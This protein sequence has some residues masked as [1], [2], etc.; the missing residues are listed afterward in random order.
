MKRKILISSIISLL[1][2]FIFIQNVY[3][4]QIFVKTQTGKTITLE[5]ESSYTIDELKAKIQE[6][7]SIDPK[8]QILIWAGKQLQDGRTLA[9][10]NIK[11]ES[12]INL[13]V[14]EE[15]P[16]GTSNSEVTGN[17][18][19]WLK[20]ESNG[21]SFWFGIDNSNGV[22][23]EQSQFW[24]RIISKDNDNAEWLNYY[25]NIDKE[26]KNDNLLMF[27]IGVTN[28]NG[29]EY[30]MLNEQVKVY[31]Q[32]PD[33][34][35]TDIKGICI[36]EAIDENIYSEI[37]ELDYPDGKTNFAALTLNHFSPY[38]IYEQ[39]YK[40]V[41]DANGGVFKD[42]K[43]TLTIEE[44]QIGDEENLEKPTKDGYKFL[45]Y[46]TEK[47][48]GTSLE[49]YIAEAGIDND[50]TF[51]AQWEELIIEDIENDNIGN[52]PSDDDNINNGNGDSNKDNI[53]DDNNTNNDKDN[54]IDNNNTN[55][56]VITNNEIINDNTNTNKIDENNPQ[57]G[58]NIV[59]FIGILVTTVIGLIITR[60]FKK[61][62]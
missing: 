38:A 35:S 59:V 44:W 32:Y 48:G 8:Q 56:N 33:D 53:I 42:G 52:V 34:W 31:I 45:G 19:I 24:V 55:N 50:L 15:Y 58:D 1:C 54:I 11:K 28:P 10:Y 51:Y 41:F 6:K 3:G 2:M 18:I 9:D 25:N 29:E 7:E 39:T 57:T 16:L 62:F 23:L 30:T 20:E 46:F 43:S 27:L 49:N 5:V 17:E 14:N 47:S 12:T 4:M 36:N 40:V 26:I 61:I 37:V 21:Q 22:F 60:K 13:I